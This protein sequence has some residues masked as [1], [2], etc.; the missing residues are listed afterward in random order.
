MANLIS[1]KINFK[2]DNILLKDKDTKKDLTSSDNLVNW[3]I[4]QFQPPKIIQ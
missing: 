4:A 3:L 1:Q 2:K